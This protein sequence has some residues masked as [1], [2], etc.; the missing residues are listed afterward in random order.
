MMTNEQQSPIKSR[1]KAIQK[2]VRL[3]QEVWEI[4]EKALVTGDNLLNN[5]LDELHELRSL[6]KNVPSKLFD[7]PSG[8]VYGIYFAWCLREC[9]ADKILAD[10]YL[11]NFVSEIYKSYWIS[12]IESSLDLR[13]IIGRLAG[14]KLQLG[15]DHVFYA[16][17]CKVLDY[18][19]DIVGINTDTS[20][21]NTTPKLS[22]RQIALVQWY[23]M[24][25]KHVEY[26]EITADSPLAERI[27]RQFGWTSGRKLA[28]HFNN[29]KK[30]ENRGRRL[31]GNKA[32][33][34]S[35]LK[36]LNTCADYLRTNGYSQ[37][38]EI[39]VDELKVFEK[40]YFSFF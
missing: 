28:Q 33:N 19:K 29:I 13:P 15:A 32:A 23:L 24:E 37:A 14:I 39:A 40:E 22:L 20:G 6:V 30:F 1:Q 34:S 9:S 38:H 21:T 3:N 26:K 27:A 35:H 36:D 2:L 18:A 5:E 8:S 16:A 4:F 17:A 7:H 12:E 10:L 25:G 11:R 31:E